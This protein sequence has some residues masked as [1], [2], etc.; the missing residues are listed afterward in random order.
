[1]K[2]NDVNE[3][4][5]MRAPNAPALGPIAPPIFASD[6]TPEE[7]GPLPDFVEIWVCHDCHM[8]HHYPDHAEGS[9]WARFPSLMIG[10]VTDWTSDPDDE[11]DD[12]DVNGHQAFSWSACDGCGSTLGGSRFRYA[13]WGD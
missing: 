3:H 8:Q 10:Q 12:Y 2:G 11:S 7:A 9:P 13:Y 4:D 5:E 1:V 6:L